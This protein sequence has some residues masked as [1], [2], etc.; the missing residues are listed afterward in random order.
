MTSM[1]GNTGMRGSSNTGGFKDKIPKGYR[2]GQIQQ[3]TPE[4][5]QLFQ[6]LFSQLGPDSFL[7][8]LAGGDEETFNQIEK[9]ALK[10]FSGLQGNFASRF[11]GAGLGAR[12]SSNFTNAS[13]QAAADFA[14]Q[15]QSQRQGL[16]QQALQDLF[17][18]SNT[19]LNQR[20][21]EKFFTQK[22][23]RGSG[24]GGILGAG[25]G[26]LGGFFAGGPTG[27]LSGAQIGYNVGNSF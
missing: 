16:Q 27:A 23:H 9:P 14:S 12:R 15:L 19:L 6:S 3:F 1:T 11:S 18:L 24:F 8:K 13:N 26:G 7:S 10:Q 20:P 25:L 4:Q 21:Q 22:Q 5:M 17:G 2:Q